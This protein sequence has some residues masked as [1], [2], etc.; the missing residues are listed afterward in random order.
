MTDLVGKFEAAALVR[1]FA[2]SGK[3]IFTIR[4]LATGQRYT[5]K[6]KKVDDKD[7]WFVSYLVGADNE[8]DYAYIGVVDGDDR[9]FRLTKKSIL[10]DDSTPVKALRYMLGNVIVND[11]I[12]AQLE[13]WHEGRCG[14]CARKLTVP[15][16]VA[17]GFGPE[18]ATR[19]MCE[20]A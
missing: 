16:S 20:A 10:G 1:D 4:S 6:F 19:I 9:F 3:A 11:T 13:I 15:E 18:C 12:P 17:R 2:F 7:L 5:Y 8:N 14:R